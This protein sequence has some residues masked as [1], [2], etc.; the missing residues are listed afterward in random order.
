MQNYIKSR[1]TGYPPTR[2]L[3]LWHQDSETSNKIKARF[4]Q[5]NWEFTTVCDYFTFDSFD[6][7]LALDQWEVDNI[8]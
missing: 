8:Y 5:E 4:H 6:D 3:Y 2:N 7:E 1:S